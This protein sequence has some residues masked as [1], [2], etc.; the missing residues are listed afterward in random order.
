M[1]KQ[2]LDRPGLSYSGVGKDSLTNRHWSTIVDYVTNYQHNHPPFTDDDQA[3]LDAITAARE[4]LTVAEHHLM[5]DYT[6]RYD[7]VRT[8]TRDAAHHAIQAMG[9]SVTMGKAGR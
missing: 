6:S 3:L 8:W 5:S 7:E 1:P 2:W 9:K 4:A